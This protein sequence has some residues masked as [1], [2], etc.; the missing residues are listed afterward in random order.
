[1]VLEAA[2]HEWGKITLEDHLESILS[3]SNCIQAVIVARGSLRIYGFKIGEAESFVRCCI[4]TMSLFYY[5]VSGILWRLLEILN[6][7]ILLT[8]ILLPF[9]DDFPG[10]SSQLRKVEARK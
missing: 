4:L 1:M 6:N 9:L 3:I 10:I 7:S 2:Q 5:L 8:V